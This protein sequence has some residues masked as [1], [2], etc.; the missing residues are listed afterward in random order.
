LELF[1]WDEETFLSD[2][3]GTPIRRAAH[4]R[5]IRNIAVALGNAPHSTETTAALA[6]KLGMDYPLVKEHVKWALDQQALKE[7]L[8]LKEPSALIQPSTKERS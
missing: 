1:N 7:P 8:A 3:E 6:D 5:W 4:E 2:T